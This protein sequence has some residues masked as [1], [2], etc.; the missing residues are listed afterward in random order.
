VKLRAVALLPVLAAAC[1]EGAPPPDPDPLPPPP[2]EAVTMA[3]IGPVTW[4]LPLD[5]AR[6]LLGQ[7]L[8]E[9]EPAAGPECGWV[10]VTLADEPLHLMVRDGRIARLDVTAPSALAAPGG[11]GI[12]STEAE[13][14]AAH[15]GTHARPH[16][17]TD[18]EYLIAVDPADTLRRI[19]F[20][21]DS[22]G[23]VAEW[24]VGRMPEVEWV[25]GCS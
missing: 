18:G 20:E 25:E 12:G 16:K 3:G 8:P 2:S 7:P 6:V 1:G 22:A 17:Y 4:G 21:T 15:P 11:G 5:S 10:T 24:R 13:V 23:V 9:L 14:R 19:V